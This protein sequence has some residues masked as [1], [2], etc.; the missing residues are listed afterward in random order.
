VEVVVATLA[1]DIQAVAALLAKVLQAAIMCTL[2]LI[3]VAAEVV[4]EA[5][6]EMLIPAKDQDRVAQEL[7][8]TSLG[9]WYTTAAVAGEHNTMRRLRPTHQAVSVAV[10]QAFMQVPE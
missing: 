9:L 7:I 6:V 2:H 5:K 1:Q 8:V 10:A 3:L 4:L